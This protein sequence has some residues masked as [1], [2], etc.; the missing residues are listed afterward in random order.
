MVQLEMGQTWVQTIRKWLPARASHALLHWRSS[1]HVFHGF[2]GY[3]KM[4]TNTFTFFMLLI[5]GSCCGEFLIS[6]AS[7]VFSDYVLSNILSSSSLSLIMRLMS[8]ILGSCCGEFYFISLASAV[9][10]DYFLSN[11]LSSSSSSFT[12]SHTH[13]HTHIAHIHTLIH[14]FIHSTQSYIISHSLTHTHTHKQ[15]MVV[16][17]FCVHCFSYVTVAYASTVMSSGVFSFIC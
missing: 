13:T 14:P 7:A 15:C 3:Y 8:L 17:P 12:H 11:K 1:L 10:S 16:L 6:L 5:L 9:F 4:L 2:F